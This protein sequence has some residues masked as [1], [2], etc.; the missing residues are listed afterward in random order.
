MLKTMKN[1][2][3]H[4]GDNLRECKQCDFASSQAGDLRTHLKHTVE[5]NQTNATSVNMLARIQVH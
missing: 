4:S 3:V 1:I 5:K 2:E